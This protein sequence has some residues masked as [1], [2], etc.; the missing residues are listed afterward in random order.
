MFTSNADKF[1]AAILKATAGWN[2]KIADRIVAIAR[3]SH[4]SLIDK[5]PVYEGKAVRNYIMTI[6]EPYTGVYDPIEDGPTGHTSTM[7]LGSEPRRPS[8]EEA[9]LESGSV[10][11]RETA[12]SKIFIT[13]NAEDIE[14]LERGELPGTTPSRS[15]NGMFAITLEEV[16]QRLNANTL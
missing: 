2:D 3:F 6:G 5:T 12:F 15:P 14:G 10:L 13:N 1:N 8:N 9:A 7:S 16:L 11:S 4:K